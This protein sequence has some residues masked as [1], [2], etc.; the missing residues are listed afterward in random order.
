VEVAEWDHEMASLWIMAKG[1][2]TL[3]QE[4]AELNG[5]SDNPI[6]SPFG[7]TRSEIETIEW[8]GAKM[9]VTPMTHL[10]QVL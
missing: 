5:E 4:H 7:Q 10:S 8:M 3:Y 2:H 1:G 6:R 9:T